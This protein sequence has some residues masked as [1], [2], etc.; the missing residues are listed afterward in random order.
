MSSDLE[1]DWDDANRRHLGLHHVPPEEAEQVIENDPLDIDAETVGGEERITSIGL[2]IPAFTTEAEEA[3]WWYD[4]RDELAKAFEDA[5]ARG[6][7]HSGTAARIAR[8]RAGSTPTTMIQLA[9]EDILRA[10]SLA[11]RRGLRYQTYLKMLIH[12]ALE[13]EE[14]KLA[15]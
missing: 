3:Q 7:L 8:E 13:A 9:P 15:S 1:F 4:H 14:K 2:T 6:E 5:A 11:A 10:H 12:D